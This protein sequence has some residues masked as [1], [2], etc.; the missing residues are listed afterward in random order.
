M[1]GPGLAVRCPACGNDLRAFPA[2]TPPT[3]WFPCPH[4]RAAVPV[5]VPRD[6]PPLYTWEVLPGLYPPLDRPRAPRWRVGAAVSIALAVVAVA[7]AVLGGA[8]GYESYA[9]TGTGSYTVS[10]VTETSNGGAAAFAHVLLTENGGTSI[11]QVASAAGRFSFSGVPSGGVSINVTYGGAYAPAT[12]YTF[13][14]PVYNTGSVGLTIVVY[15]LSETNGT[16][17]TLT[18]FPDLESFL[19]SIDGAVA[20]LGLAAIVSGAAAVAI[21]VSHPRAVGVVGGGAGVA[22]PAIVYLLG[23]FPAF[24]L[25]DAGTAIAAGFGLFAVGITAVELYQAGP[26]DAAA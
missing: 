26:R 4:C 16:T 13:V 18:D 7:S 11:A 6:P 25:I 20:L 17:V 9:A 12:L 8:L 14:D 2:P 15:P 5:V 1:A 24:P 19:S 3:Q 10:G 23:L 22:V 21:R